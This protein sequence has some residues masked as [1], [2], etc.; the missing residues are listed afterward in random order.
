MCPLPPPGATQ[1]LC[2]NVLKKL[3][4]QPWPGKMASLMNCI[5]VMD[6]P[7]PGTGPP[8]D[9]ATEYPWRPTLTVG[10]PGGVERFHDSFKRPGVALSPVPQCRSTTAVMIADVFT[11]G[12]RPFPPGG[13]ASL[14]PPLVDPELSKFHHHICEFYRARKREANKEVPPRLCFPEL[15]FFLNSPMSTVGRIELYLLLSMC[16]PQCGDQVSVFLWCS[17]FTAN[18]REICCMHYRRHCL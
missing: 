12:T 2:D 15:S 16:P 5:I 10:F 17:L 9:E 14:R 3:K 1:Q 4:R 11:R 7:G 13:R 6:C 8:G 18:R